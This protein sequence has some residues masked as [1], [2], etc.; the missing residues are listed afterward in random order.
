MN[1]RTINPKLCNGDYLTAQREYKANRMHAATAIGLIANDKDF[2]AQCTL[3]HWAIGTTA[4][5]I[6]RDLWA[7]ERYLSA[8]NHTK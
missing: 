2:I 7:K 5:A 3:N 1:I 4:S 8:L 6:V